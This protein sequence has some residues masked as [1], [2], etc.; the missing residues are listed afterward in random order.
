VADEEHLK[1]IRQGAAAW[2]EWREKNPESFGDLSNA[3]LSLADLFRANLSGANLTWAQ[4]S[5]ANLSKANLCDANLLWANLRKANLSEADLSRANLSRA[6]LLS[7]NLRKANLLLWAD[8]SGADLTEANL[9][10]ANLSGANLTG[11]YL[12]GAN[13]SGADLNRAQLI[14]TN[15]HN[16]TLTGSSVYGVSVWD[17]KVNAR[18]KQHNLIITD[19]DQ[20]VITVDNIKVAQFIYLLLNN[21]E[22]RDVLDT[23]TSKAV[24]ILGRFSEERKPV[25]D[26]LRDE[27]RKPENNYL[28]IVF[29]FPPSANQTL[30]ETVKTLAN[31]ARFV[32]ADL[33]DARS[34]L[35]ELQAIVPALPSVAVRLLIKK[36]AHEYGMLD[37]I[38]KFASVVNE[39]Y[40]YESLEEVIASI[41]EKVIGPAEAKVREL[42]PPPAASSEQY[43]NTPEK[44]IM[45]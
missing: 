26:A 37:Y 7:A 24:L 17:I 14:E 21:Q 28:P 27:L 16:T 18:T 23:I 4:L 19:Y 25:L 2:N 32:I 15:L 33:T 44:P 40:E 45:N 3:D 43:Q 39:A 36:S 12:G 38:R 20:P 29:D 10:E 9:S 35:Q 31:M 6:N 34:V 11:A 42:R 30:L 1:I 22:I 8:L 13:L 41:K 5:R